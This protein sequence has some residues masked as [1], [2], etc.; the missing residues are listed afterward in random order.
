M[1]QD[2][3][4]KYDDNEPRD[5]SGKWTDGGGS[6]GGGSGSAGSAKPADKPEPSSGKGGKGKVAAV[7]DFSKKGIRLDHDTTLNASKA[8]KFLSRWNDRVAEA[9]EDF[10]KEFL[11]GMPGT[12]NISYNDG[13]DTM[14]VTGK[15]Q[16]DGK[17]IGEYQRTLDLKNNSA[18]SAYFVMKKNERGG[19]VGKTLLKSNVAMYQKLGFDK[20]TVSA[21]IDVGG[22]AWAKYGYV[23]TAA[24]WSSLSSDI[25]DKLTNDGDR[26]SHAASGSGYTPE[27]WDMISEHDQSQIE[28]AWQRSTHDEFVE[29]EVQNWRD[30]GQALQQAKTDLV[31][32]FNDDQQKWALAAIEEWRTGRDDEGAG[33]PFTNEQILSA[34]TADDYN[35]RYDEGKADPEFTFDLDK[36]KDETQ[37]SL[38]GLEAPSP[39]SE[40]A[41][42]EITDALTKSFNDEAESKAQDEDPPQYI[43]DSVSEYQDEYWSSMEDEQKYDWAERNGE[44]PEY[45]MEDDEEDRPEPVEVTDEQQDALMK[46]ARSSDPKALWAIADSE[47]GKQLLLG[48]SW[49]GVL[50]LKDKQTMDRFNAYVGK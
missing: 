36:L 18:Y 23:P 34:I 31:T 44:L 17:E 26:S 25:R 48:T 11:G 46:L 12:M 7:A 2:A 40:T 15:L 16:E 4:V 3:R 32:D 14:S 30:S 13:S 35:D 49:S 37:P 47:K 8:E 43:A 22:Y 21:N 50:D 19:G 10:K 24:S 42:Q 5:E 9:P 20:V 28:T 38:P 27:S 29:S 39:L 41:Q 6:G 45:P 1:Q 33:I